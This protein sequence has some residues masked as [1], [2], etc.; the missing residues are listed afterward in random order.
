MQ[1]PGGYPNDAGV[2]IQRD[3]FLGAPQAET[4]AL[5]NLTTAERPDLILNM[6]T[7]TNFLQILRPFVEPAL[8]KTRENIYQRDHTRLTTEGL[9]ATS[10]SDR[11]ADPSRLRLSPYN[12]DT[13]LNLN[14]GA[15]AMTVESPSHDHSR[16]KQNGQPFTHTVEQI[17]TAHLLCHQEA[18]RFLA[19]SGGRSGW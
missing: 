4:R 13:A 14:C 18:M 9:Q 19:E 16:A 8:D 11:Q 7:G 6:H 3:D 1:F 17:V 5:L 15:L 12:L 2:N 10:D